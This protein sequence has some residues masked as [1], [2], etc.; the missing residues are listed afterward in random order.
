M[1]IYKWFSNP[2]KIYLVWVILIVLFLFIG[3]PILSSGHSGGEQ[4]PLTLLA[5]TLNWL[6]YG[7]LIISLITPFLFFVWFKRY[8][9]I[10]II[11]A[12]ISIF[13]LS[14]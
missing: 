13:L 12:L 7:L 14:L 9:Y 2:W 4:K 11:V 10:N 1:N 3:I 5:Y 8:W 6:F